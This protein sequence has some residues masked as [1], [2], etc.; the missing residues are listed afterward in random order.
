FDHHRCHAASSFLVSPFD[1]AAVLVVDGVGEHS[2]TTIWHGRGSS[3][4]PVERIE[5]PHSLG[6]LYAG[7]TSYLGFA[8]N[9]GEYKVMGLAAWGRDRYRER[10]AK[11]IRLSDDGSYELELEYFAHMS[12]A[13]LGFGPAL[14]RLLGPRRPPDLPW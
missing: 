14:E 9:E 4:R 5:F 11:L 3:L 10:F 13:A 6:L 1:D 2:S 7:L 8:V 12:D